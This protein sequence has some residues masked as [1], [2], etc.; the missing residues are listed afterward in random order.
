VTARTEIPA[1]EWLGLVPYAEALRF[2]NLRREAVLAGHSPEAF[3]LLEHP[4]VVTLGRRGGEVPEAAWLHERGTALHRTDR[5]GLA[6]WHGPGQLVG[7]LIVDSRRHGLR[8]PAF[9]AA[10]EDGIIAALAGLGIVAGRRAGYPGVWAGNRKLAAIGLHFRDRVSMHGFALNLRPDL[11]AFSWIV[12]CG[13]TDGGVSSVLKET[14]RSPSPEQA[15]SNVGGHV[16]AA[17]LDA[18]AKA[19]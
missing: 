12:P 16:R 6:T 2:Q 19:C 15:W 13:I 18:A 9:V 7:Y 5:G 10:V 3:W 8:I 11:T 1:P 4:S 17:M 14:G